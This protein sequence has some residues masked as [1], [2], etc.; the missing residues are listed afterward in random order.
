ML[1]SVAK[2]GDEGT[3]QTLIEKL[4]E[5]FPVEKRH[6]CGVHHLIINH[7]DVTCL[8]G[9]TKNKELLEIFAPSFSS[10]NFSKE[11]G[12]A[13]TRELEDLGVEIEE[14]AI[15]IGGVKQYT[16]IWSDAEF[17]HHEKK[18]L[19]GIQV[20]VEDRSNMI[21]RLRVAFDNEEWGSWR[22]TA[23]EW[24]TLVEQPALLLQEGEEIIGATTHAHV[25]G[26]LSSLELTLSTGRR[27]FWGSTKTEGT[28]RIKSVLE[29]S[30]LAYL[31]GGRTRGDS[32]QL[33]FHWE[34]PGFSD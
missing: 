11:E 4:K 26:S 9:T 25:D 10:S 33:T 31:S 18:R 19:T 20:V 1:V 5:Q 3:M 12:E 16:E 27:Q 8:L 13:L 14:P 17:Y 34:G 23:G 7:S 28:T 29:E 6:N 22:E 24:S 30:K 2:A 15:W 21:S 32:F